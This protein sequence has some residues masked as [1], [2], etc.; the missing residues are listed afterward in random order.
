MTWKTFLTSSIHSDEWR[1]GWNNPFKD[2]DEHLVLIRPSILCHSILICPLYL[3]CVPLSSAVL[4]RF[5]YYYSRVLEGKRI[6]Q[7]KEHLHSLLE[8]LDSCR[9]EPVDL[10]LLFPIVVMNFRRSPTTSFGQDEWMAMLVF[11][12]L[13]F[14][15]T[16]VEYHVWEKKIFSWLLSGLFSRL[17]LRPLLWILPEFLVIIILSSVV[18]C[19]RIYLRGRSIHANHSASISSC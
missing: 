12:F 8:R 1:M 10:S 13:S 7:T 9:F 11:R 14:A 19:P 2:L 5:Y 6:K 17:W 15:C 3:L 4:L 16:S 18:F